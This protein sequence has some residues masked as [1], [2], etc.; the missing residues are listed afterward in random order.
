MGLMDFLRT[1]L[2]DII[3]WN[4]E[5]SGDV[6][7]WRF[8]RHDNEIKNGAKLIVREGQVALFVNM[9]KLADIFQPGMYTLET[10][11]LPLLST[12][13]GWK[14]GFDS[15]FKAEVYFVSTRRFTDLKWGTQNAMLIRD[16]EFG[17]TRIRA[18]GSYAAQVSKPDNFLRQL[19]ATDPVFN[20]FEVQGQL[21]NIIVTRASDAMASSGIPVLDMAGNLDELST[22][23]KQRIAPDFDEMG[24]G[25]PIFLI[26]NISLPPNVE[27]ALD[28]RTSMGVIGN[29]D[30]YTKFQMANS[31]PDAMKNPG[32][33]AATGAGLAAGL[34][35]GH[36]MM[37]AMGGAMQTGGGQSGPPPIPGAPSAS[38]WFAA[39]GGKQ[40][41]PMDAA[42]IHQQISS[43]EIKR[44]TLVWRQGMG[45]WT[46]AGEVAEFKE[47]FASV[48][49]PIPGL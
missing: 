23:V 41:P 32:G 38:P 33:L 18:Y 17:P 48:P 26:E 31:I 30:N 7:A 20:S 46:A 8:P 9:G 47:M 43:G 14:Y 25:V 49:P 1:E 45:A 27:E 40:T 15:P 34:A 16:K 19:I 44:E 39:I 22:L 6:M 12:L 3:E 29:L 37:G 11:N 10:K 24:I 28:K 2:I 4:Q 35:M 5:S 42:T 21:R 36:Q 13:M